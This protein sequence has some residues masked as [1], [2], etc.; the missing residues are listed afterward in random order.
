M[1]R[2]LLAADFARGRITVLR[3]A[4]TACAAGEGLGGRRLE[5]FVLAVNEITTNAVLHGGGGGR[6]RLWSQAGRLWCEVTDEGPGLPPG[7]M[8]AE[9]TPSRYDTGGRGLWL[10]R[11]LC[12]QVTIVSTPG[13]GTSVTFS[14][15]RG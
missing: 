12:D 8:G 9:R 4:V 3:R 15:S 1:C 2:R 6:L 11:L 13:G 5:D 14:A 10:T 7:W